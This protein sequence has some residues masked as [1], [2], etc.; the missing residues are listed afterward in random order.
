MK[1]F[2]G[3]TNKTT[4]YVTIFI[5]LALLVQSKTQNWSKC[6]IILTCLSNC[7]ANCD[8]KIFIVIL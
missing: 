7:E 3:G 8:N 6:T 2:F 4:G 5:K 1:G